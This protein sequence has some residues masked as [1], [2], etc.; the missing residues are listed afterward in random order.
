[1]T[2]LP[3]VIF[4][5]LRYVSSKRVNKSL[6]EAHNERFVS[7]FCDDYK[8]SKDLC[9]MSKINLGFL[10]QDKSWTPR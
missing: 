2:S 9:W 4:T 7:R 3:V 5:D 6:F 1:M 8:P 10:V